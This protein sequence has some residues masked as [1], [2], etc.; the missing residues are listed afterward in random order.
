MFNPN[1]I[2]NFEENSI[3][4]NN[5]GNLSLL[6][7]SGEVICFTS[8]VIDDTPKL[9]VIDKVSTSPY[10][11]EFLNTSDGW[12]PYNPE[13]K[14]KISAQTQT[15]FL[16]TQIDFDVYD[17]PLSIY[18][19]LVDN[20]YINVSVVGN[21]IIPSLT[22]C[23][24]YS[25]ID[26]Q[27]ETGSI[28]YRSVEIYEDF[29]TPQ[30]YSIIDVAPY[31]PIEFASPVIWNLR[32]TPY[33]K[34][35]GDNLNWSSNQ[36]GLNVNSFNDNL[37]WELSSYGFIAESF[38]D[39]LSWELSSYGFIA[40]SFNDN[41][42][43]ELSS[44]GFIAE[45]FSDNLSWNIVLDWPYASSD[46]LNP[47][48]SA[49]KGE[50]ETSNDNWE[51]VSS[52]IDTMTLP[53]ERG[54]YRACVRYVMYMQEEDAYLVL[55]MNPLAKTQLTESQYISLA[56]NYFPDAP[57]ISYKNSNIKIL[58]IQFFGSR[59]KVKDDTWDFQGSTE[60]YRVFYLKDIV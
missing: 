57:F 28:L 40:E 5:Y 29:E 26:I 2:L 24:P 18:G 49:V 45:S 27:I 17:F 50:N 16:G 36:Y 38:N 51:M 56:M 10:Y 23:H 21:S 58:A 43:W 8:S 1:G 52:N 53:S 41:L 22:D 48:F 42:S 11:Q 34:S 59:L 12:V 37:S 32:L 19:I 54:R 6:K 30:D 3:L 44:Y 14:I 31:T 4:I 13:Q 7:P 15:F 55:G 9:V 35:F 25:N 60:Y 47:I 20:K 33:I 46:Q 39:N